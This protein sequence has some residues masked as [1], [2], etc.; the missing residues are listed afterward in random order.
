MIDRFKQKIKNTWSSAG[1]R[2]YF[3]NTNWLLFDKILRM[4][5]G[6]LVGVWVARYLGPDK[7]GLYSYVSSFVF[8]FV[9]FINLGLD[10]LV[11][12]ELIQKKYSEEEILGTSFL[13]KLFGSFLMVFVILIAI[14]FTSNDSYTNK[15][16][17][18][19][20]FGSI[21]QT[22][23][24]IDFYFQS[25]VLSKFI[26]YSNIISLILI[27]IFKVILI[28]LDAPLI[29]FIIAV[30]SDFI[31]I[32]FGF[33]YF[34]IKK[35][36]SLLKWKFNI[37][38]FKKFLKD[39]WP[40]ILSAG[41]ITIYNKIDQVMLKEITTNTEVGIYSAALKLSTTWYFI[42]TLI[43]NSVFPALIQLKIN[44]EVLFYKR[45]QLLYDSLIWLA[46]IIS[47][48]FFFTSDLI[49]QFLFGD[50]YIKS[51]TVLSIHIWTG[52]L[53]FFGVARQKWIII[54]N[55]QK[56]VLILNI[57]IAIINIVLN[58]ILI[59]K[60]GA[61]G[62]AYATLFS[63]LIGSLFGSLLIKKYHK[64]FIM[65]IKSLTAPIRLFRKQY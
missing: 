5:F 49:I 42:P 27:S 12:R 6:L 13:M 52:I 54:E 38:V 44:N 60:Y 25:I 24:V 40:I 19:F 51:S 17:Y 41:M 62:A 9:L 15:L 36:G 65:F 35:S 33:L 64:S 22:F 29:Y 39:C 63:F 21:F 46:I 55:T 23:N 37:L 28:L 4:T 3:F 57:L 58:I 43:T 31:I 56:W 32:S 1:F 34:Y 30:A 50:E 48:I 18:I 59:P 61:I 2:K 26:V 16:I 14:Q 11:V 53:V 45:L 20:A 10:H 7:F 8:L 47:I